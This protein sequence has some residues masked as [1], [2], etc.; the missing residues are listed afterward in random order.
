MSASEPSSIRQPLL[1]LVLACSILVAAFCL[2]V[3]PEDRVSIREH[4]ELK[5]PPLCVTN[6]LLGFKCPGCGLTR[7]F[8]HL[9]HG[10]VAA[11][12]RSHRLGW[13][14]FAL[15][16]ASIP[17]RIRELCQREKSKALIAFA[18]WS[19]RILVMLL[20]VN[21]AGELIFFH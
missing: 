9:A 7:S 3:T 20:L 5:L 12:L 10:D 13:L 8:V 2:Q 6:L 18:N 14:V 4:S 15:I 17:Y 21:W 19:G 16:L 1:F 11:S